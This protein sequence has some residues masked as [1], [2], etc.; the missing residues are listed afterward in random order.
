[1]KEALLALWHQPNIPGLCHKIG[2]R[3]VAVRGTAVPNEI[4][5]EKKKNL[6]R[7]REHGMTEE[8]V[9][10]LPRNPTGLSLAKC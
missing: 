1:M 3:K 7:T 5:E 2:N 6:Q 10:F 4:A 8:I 9:S